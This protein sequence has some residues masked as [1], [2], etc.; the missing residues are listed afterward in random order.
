MFETITQYLQ[1]VG[2]IFLL[3]QITEHGIF[4]GL[5]ADDA[6]KHNFTP[7]FFG[8]GFVVVA[9]RV[10]CKGPTEN[11]I[12]LHYDY[13]NELMFQPPSFQQAAR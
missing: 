7:T 3:S 8:E 6:K 5:P 10:V 9:V 13:A 11:T 12:V 4:V 1:C 2:V